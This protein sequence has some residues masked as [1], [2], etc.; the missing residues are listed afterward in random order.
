[1]HGLMEESIYTKAVTTL[2]KYI[3]SQTPI[4]DSLFEQAEVYFESSAKDK[5]TRIALQEDIAKIKAALLA[6]NRKR[7]TRLQKR[8]DDA[9]RTYKNERSRQQELRSLRYQ[10]ATEVSGKLLE[11]TEG[12]NW[13]V[14]QTN[15]AK[16]L[17]TLQLLS[18]KEGAKLVPQHQRL[19]PAYKGV[20]ALRLLDK[21]LLDEQ[22][23]NRYINQ[24]HQLN[25]RY[26]QKEGELTPFQLNVAI[27]V[28]ITALFQDVG[29]LH[30]KA[31][32]LLKGE[33]GC[34]NEFRVL[35][36]D[37][38]LTLLKINHEQTMDYITYGLGTAKYEGRSK[39]E[40]IE[41][42]HNEKERLNFT[43]MLIKDALKPKLGLGNL[44]KAPQIY[45][46][47]IFSTKQSYSFLDLPKAGLIIAKAAKAGAISTVAANS[48]LAIVGHFPQGYGITYIPKDN[49][50]Q[51]RDSYEYAI[52]NELN[53]D[54][55]YIPK[56]RT[57][58]RN[59]TFISSGKSI[60]INTEN[61]LFFRSA[62]KKLEKVN[63]ARL[64]EILRKLVSNFEERKEV[65]LIPSY[66]NPY[67]F[68]C[69]SKPQNI[70]KKV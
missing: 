59:L 34:L 3:Q 32:L 4:K 40:K 21:L 70:W 16:L 33:D 29:L 57:V 5:E 13:Q 28:L 41:F 7:N 44:L 54:D 24:Y 36:K 68:F 18:P 60:L 11:L 64:E 12:E 67:G 22:I 6:S 55:P 31:Q 37:T 39:Q 43:R 10:K 63:P 27:P 46:S 23:T 26:P 53:P 30:P 47:V 51:D 17:G 62:R 19:K 65:G 2:V 1:M 61:N 58:T 14:T 8:L 48:L 56:C 69:Y 66:W 15:S 25:Q 42:E 20:I 45:T 49:E 52:V 35:D 50:G 38:R 9:Q